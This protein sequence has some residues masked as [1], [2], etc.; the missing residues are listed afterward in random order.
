VP[1]SLHVGFVV[2]K[3]VLGQVFSEF[4]G[5]PCQYIIP[6]SLSISSSTGMSNR[7]V[8]GRNSET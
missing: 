7:P 5:F 2:D 3:V 1:R 8:G 4:F 6:P